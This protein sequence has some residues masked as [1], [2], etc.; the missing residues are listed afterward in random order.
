MTPCI[1]RLHDLTDRAANMEFCSRIPMCT[2]YIFVTPVKATLLE[3][4]QR[5]NGNEQKKT[6]QIIFLSL[7]HFEVPKECTRQLQEFRFTNDVKS[8]VQ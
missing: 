2:S 1:F 8:H 5:I 7:N 4:L 3:N 6:T